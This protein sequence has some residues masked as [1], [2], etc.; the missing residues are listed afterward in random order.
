MATNHLSIGNGPVNKLVGV[1]KA[2]T[3]SAGCCKNVE[4]FLVSGSDGR[5]SLATHVQFGPTALEIVNMWL[6]DKVV[7]GIPS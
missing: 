7:K 6:R 2:E 4:Q 5:E 1:A 3:S